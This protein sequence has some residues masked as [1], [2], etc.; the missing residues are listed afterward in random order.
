MNHHRQTVIFG[1]AL[2]YD[3]TTESY[4][5][6]FNT[7]IKAMSGKK[8]KTILTDQCQAM[9]NAIASILP[10]THHRLCLWHI[11]QNATV[12]LGHMFGAS[13]SFVFAFKSC[14]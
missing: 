6:V 12:Q 2:L 8:P 3:E 4:K 7:F 13:K 9:A 5:W 1:A 11:Y 14:I 10:E